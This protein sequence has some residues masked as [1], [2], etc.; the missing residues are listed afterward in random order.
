MIEPANH[1]GVVDRFGDT[2]VRIDE[3]PGQYGT[4]WPVT[5]GPGWDAAGRDA[6][7]TARLWLDVQDYGPLTPADA[8]RTARALGL[9][10]RSQA[11]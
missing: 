10:V 6:V 2:W 3:L 5:D 4:W 11:A 9:V 8:E 1:A 7:G